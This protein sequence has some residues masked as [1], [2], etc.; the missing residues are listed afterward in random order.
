MPL[1]AKRAVFAAKGR[2][3]LLETKMFVRR[4][5][6]IFLTALKAAFVPHTRPEYS[7]FYLD[8]G[9]RWNWYGCRT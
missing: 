4:F 8:S 6:G 5:G 3:L 2:P 9:P 1:F 7:V